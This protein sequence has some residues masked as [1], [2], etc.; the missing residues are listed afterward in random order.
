MSIN[1]PDTRDLV[2]AVREFLETRVMPA[3]DEHAA[4]HTR[5]AANVLAIVERELDLGPDLDAEERERLRHLLGKEGTLS[6]LN[7]ELC[8]QIREGALDYHDPAL[9]EHLYKTTLGRMS[10]DNPR[11]SAYRK[12]TF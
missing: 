4:F 12:A 3:V 9:V 6:E 5:V 2:E 7:R 8:L 10:I 11:Y 1:R